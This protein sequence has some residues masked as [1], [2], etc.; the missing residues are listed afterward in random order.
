MSDD[1]IEYVEEYARDL[2]RAGF[3]NRDPMVAAVASYIE[4]EDYEDQVSP[5]ELIDNAIA[6]HE[7]AQ[8]TWDE[9][10]DFA[11]LDQAFAALYAE[12]ILPRH[13]YLFS[14]Q[15]AMQGMIEELDDESDAGRP[16]KGYVLYH[17]QDTM[18][19]LDGDG[20][21]LFFGSSALDPTEEDD[22]AIGETVAAKLQEAGLTVIWDHHVGARIE[23]EFDWKRY[24][25]TPS[26]FVQQRMFD[27]QE[28]DELE[29]KLFG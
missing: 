24:W 12:G 5:S 7:Q 8:K 10:T 3:H 16:A 29:P 18:S 17:R 2:V 21:L 11:K 26:K 15:D 19:A 25:Q 1:D 13:D 6:T 20:L 14:A 28:G 23:V 9:P 27:F 4:G 22:L